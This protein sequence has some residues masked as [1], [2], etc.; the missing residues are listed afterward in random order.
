MTPERMTG[1]AIPSE[2]QI[3]RKHHH[4]S[5]DERE[6]S[7]AERAMKKRACECRDGQPDSEDP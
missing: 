1:E 7:I 2:Q 6:G 3:R 4:C 5:C